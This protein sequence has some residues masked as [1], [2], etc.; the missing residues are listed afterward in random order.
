MHKASVKELNGFLVAKI[1]SYY[2]L[3]FYVADYVKKSNCPMS[4]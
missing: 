1:T 2:V 4:I 3:W